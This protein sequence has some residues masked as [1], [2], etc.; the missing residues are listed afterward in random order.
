[1]KTTIRKMSESES[2]CVGPRNIFV[3][4]FSNAGFRALVRMEALRLS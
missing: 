1:M 2:K 3:F 4:F